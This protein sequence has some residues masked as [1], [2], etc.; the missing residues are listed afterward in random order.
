MV[1]KPKEDKIDATLKEKVDAIL[2]E[3]ETAQAQKIKP[4]EILRSIS[5]SLKKE[6]A[7]AIPLIEG[8]GR[9]PTLF[10]AQLLQK[11]MDSTKEKGV[12]KA[13]KRTQFKL[14]QKGVR[15]ETKTKQE[16]SVLHL[17]KPG[18]PQGYLGGMDAT[19]SRIIMVARPRPVGGVRVYFS[20]INDL[21]GIQR[22]ELNNLTKKGF[23]E[24]VKSSLSS[25]EFPVVEAPGEYCLHLMKE[26]SEI[27]D[28]LSISLPQ[29]YK[30]AENEVQDIKW[31][32]SIPLIYQFI[33]EGEVKDQVRLL[34]ESGKLH[35]I[36][37]FSLWFLNPE[38]VRKY[39][40]AIKKAE[41]SR[42]VLTP[43][44][45]DARLTSIYME[46]LQEI[47]P[48]GKRL[49]WKRRLEEMAYILWKLGK[50]RDAK[51]AL[52]AAVDLKNP[53][54][55]IEPN[56]FVWNLLIKS[57][58][59]LMEPFYKEREKEKEASLIVTP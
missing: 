10:T 56:P 52:S 59:G 38:E 18:E 16:K 46:A 14:R 6:P 7:I 25:V 49:L 17:P 33:K 45:K 32:G 50:E 48:E 54:A 15:W 2:Q 28:R 8:L 51:K 40:E 34:K 44:Q 31:N 20:I 5:S 37:P 58:Y 26:A 12:I 21:E 42:I 35:R 41:E 57:I 19:G 47:F 43:D 39:A 30:D 13:I 3:V 29:G 27:S 23:R 11:M 24:F 36:P 1:K 22:F 4:K 55:T 9:I 53:F